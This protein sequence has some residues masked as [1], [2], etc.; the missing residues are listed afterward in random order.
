MNCIMSGIEIHNF[1][2]INKVFIVYAPNNPSFTGWV[3]NVFMRG[4]VLNNSH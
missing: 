1:F 4:I 2:V 3:Q